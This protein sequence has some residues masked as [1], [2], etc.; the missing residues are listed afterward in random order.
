[1]S[2]MQIRKFGAKMRMFQSS[3]TVHAN[4]EVS[5]GQMHNQKSTIQFK[6]SSVQ[7]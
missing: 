6:R 3:R 4:S 1:M 2:F 7:I 5:L